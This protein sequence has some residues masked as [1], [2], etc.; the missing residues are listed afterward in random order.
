MEAIGTPHPRTLISEDRLEHFANFLKEIFFFGALKNVHMSWC[1]EGLEEKAD[2]GT[3]FGATRPCTSADRR[4]HAIRL[5]D[6][7]TEHPKSLYARPEVT[8]ARERLGT[9]LHDLLHAFLDE[10][11]CSERT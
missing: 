11:A 8:L 4:R 1:D 3:L 5:Y 2:F 6:T 9:I 10:F 7:R